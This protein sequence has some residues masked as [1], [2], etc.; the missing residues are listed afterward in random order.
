MRG[1]VFGKADMPGVTG[2]DLKAVDEI[3]EIVEPTTVLDRRQLRAIAIA[4]WLLPVRFPTT[5]TTLRCSARKIKDGANDEPSPGLAFKITNNYRK[6]FVR[7]IEGRNV[8]A[9]VA[10]PELT[11]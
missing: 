4:K 8:A 6:H 11:P 1:Y 2:R 7:C 5:S 3:D 10:Q 9:T